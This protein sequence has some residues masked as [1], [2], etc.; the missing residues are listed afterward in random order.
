MKKGGISGRQASYGSNGTILK[1]V[2][3]WKSLGFSL[4]GFKWRVW[5]YI[6]GSGTLCKPYTASSNFSHYLLHL[7]LKMN[8]SD[9]KLVNSSYRYI[10]FTAD[11]LT[12]P[13][14]T[15]WR[16]WVYIWCSML[17]ATI[18]DQIP[19]KL[20]WNC[21][22]NSQFWLKTTQMDPKSPIWRF[23]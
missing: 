3:S 16:V 6:W 4:P 22:R 5:V 9:K 19:N 10:S 11:A 21:F 17:H 23:I 15:L 7:E 18:C 20:G 8:F 2:K 12:S 1:I 14:R 13:S